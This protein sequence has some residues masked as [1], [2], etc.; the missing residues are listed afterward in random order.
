MKKIVFILSLVMSAPVLYVPKGL[1]GVFEIGSAFAFQRSNFSETSYTWTRR[2]S[3]SFGYYFTQDSQVAFVFQDS[4]TRTFVQQ[5]QDVSFHDQVYS[6][7]L[8]YYLLK[9]QDP[10]RPYFKLGIGQL[11]RDATGTYEGG[12]APPGR[13]DQITGIIGLGVKLRASER[14]GFKAEA[15]SYLTG[16]AIGTW[17][18][19]LTFS[20][21]G[22]FFL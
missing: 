7:D 14:L 13:V 21:G 15:S 2:Y 19:N 10:F 16:G 22:S 5:V 8:S 18:D 6:I 20:V 9:E 12:Y 17:K 3:F 1:A 4:T 11:N